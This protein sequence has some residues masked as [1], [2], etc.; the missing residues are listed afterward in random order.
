MSLIKLKDIGFGLNGKTLD[1]TIAIPS[2]SYLDKLYVS[3]QDDVINSCPSNVGIE[4]FE[5][6]K[7]LHPEMSNSE[8]FLEIFTK[9]GEET[10][11]NTNNIY[12]IYQI[13]SDFVWE[14]YI[15]TAGS[16]NS[17]KGVTVSQKDITFI[18]MHVAGVEVSESFTPSAECG[19][20]NTTLVVP[21]CNL[22]PLRLA[23]LN[24]FKRSSECNINREFVD[25]ILQIKA[26]EVALCCE[27][28]CYAAKF[29]KQFW[30]K[31]EVKQSKKCG[32]YGGV[33]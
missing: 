18:E 21:L 17:K 19:E 4:Y 23:A 25:K 13:K 5:K 10:D 11:I 33:A 32:C 30:N 1:I 14:N 31:K 16:L 29:W 20:D 24:S 26:I 6:V 7:S 22:T 12:D 3:N 27:H 9:L 8:V 2:G 15:D 28:Y